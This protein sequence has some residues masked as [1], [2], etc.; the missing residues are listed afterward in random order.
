MSRVG[1]LRRTVRAIRG[2]AFA[3]FLAVAPSSIAPWRLDPRLVPVAMLIVG[4]PTPRL[5]ARPAPGSE[6]P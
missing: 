2:V 1:I 4:D 5:G 6:T 3:A